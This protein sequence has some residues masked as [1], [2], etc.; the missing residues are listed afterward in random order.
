MKSSSR[1]K[2][3]ELIIVELNVWL[4]GREQIRLCHLF[5]TGTPSAN[6]VRG[7]VSCHREQEVMSAECRE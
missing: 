4:E 7:G 6:Q 2:Q 5:I 1:L 3:A